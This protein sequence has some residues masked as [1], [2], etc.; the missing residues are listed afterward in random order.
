MGATCKRKLPVITVLIIS[1][2]LLLSSC[3][4]VEKIINA[5]YGV[6][7]KSRYND[8]EYTPADLKK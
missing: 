5:D 7:G 1:G 6:Y 8:A 4:V 2:I 3:P